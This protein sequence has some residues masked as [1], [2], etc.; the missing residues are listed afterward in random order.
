MLYINVNRHIIFAVF[1][2]KNLVLLY[3]IRYN[4][5]ELYLLLGGDVMFLGKTAQGR[6]VKPINTV[7]ENGFVYPLNLV[8]IKGHKN[9]YAFVMGV[10]HTVCNFDGRIIAALVP[11]DPENTELKNIYIMASRSSRYIN[12]DIY[13]YIDVKNDFP[14]YDLVCYYE[15]SAGAVVY[16]CIKGKL[17]FL[18]I[19]NKR[20]SNWGFPKGHLE[21]GETK[22]D[23]ARREVLEETGLHIKIHL[24]Y[25]GISKY[26]LR[27]NVDKKVSI[28]VATTDDLRTTIQEEEIDDYRWLAYDQ[29]MGHLSFENDKKI[30]REA[31]DFLIKKQLIV[32]KNTPTKE[33]IDKEIAIKEQ[34]RKERIAEYR[35]QKWIEQQK[36]IRAQR[37]Y[38]THKEEIIQQKII[39]RR[40]RSQEKRRLQKQQ[41]KLEAM[42]NGEN[43]QSLENKAATAATVQNANADKKE[44]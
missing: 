11:K 39:K 21:M 24:G 20:S 32:N 15:S 2:I 41:A 3:K 6:V 27:N 23:A 18:L 43:I 30:L 14:D 4:K 26:T 8:Q 12:Q 44:N 13:Q 19:K 29:A 37:Y 42:N 25:E 31:V 28:F 35:R 5:N 16:R 1:I 34:E 40:K 10:T 38:E 33:A 7:D 36:K 17:R 9:R 22:Y